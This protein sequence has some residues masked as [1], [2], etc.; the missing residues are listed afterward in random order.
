MDNAQCKRC[1]TQ[2]SRSL[3]SDCAFSWTNK[4]D[5]IYT[6]FVLL[7]LKIWCDKMVCLRYHH[8]DKAVLLQ[9]MSLISHQ[10]D[11]KVLLNLESSAQLMFFFFS[12]HGGNMLSTRYST[13]DTDSDNNKNIGWNSRFSGFRACLAI[14]ILY[15]LIESDIHWYKMPDDNIFFFVLSVMCCWD[16]FFTAL[17]NLFHYNYYLCHFNIFQERKCVM[18]IKFSLLS[19]WV[20]ERVCV[21]VWIIVTW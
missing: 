21:C 4:R 7:L 19:E 5:C 12:L 6:T 18:N 3:T 8:A 14:L 17:K 11:N 13:I 1:S 10:W 16:G 9:I 20:S 2:Q 15:S